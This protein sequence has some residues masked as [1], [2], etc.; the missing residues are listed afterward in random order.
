VQLGQLLKTPIGHYTILRNPSIVQR[1]R[2]LFVMV[3]V[4]IATCV[5]DC[6]KEESLKILYACD[7]VHTR[8]NVQI[9]IHQGFVG[10]CD[11]CRLTLTSAHL[12]FFLYL[13]GVKFMVLGTY[14]PPIT[15]YQIPLSFFQF[16]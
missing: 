6:F 2:T 13:L 1:V 4:F 7:S 15:R 5:L 14:S 11:P 3:L 16:C 8:A 9:K 10:H 12:F